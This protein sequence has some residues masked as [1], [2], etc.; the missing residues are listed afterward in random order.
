[1]QKMVFYRFVAFHPRYYN[2][3]LQTERLT[4]KELNRN[5][6]MLEAVNVML[7]R[8]RFSGRQIYLITGK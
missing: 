3:V 5:S 7:E 8:E 2:G 4:E 6:F 1:M